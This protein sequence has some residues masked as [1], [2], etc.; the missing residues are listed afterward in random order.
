M[1]FIKKFEDIGVD[2][3][4]LVGGKNESLGRMIQDLADAGIAIP[5]GFAITSKAYW[6]YLEQNK[7][8]N[9]IEQLMRSI[10][11]IDD[12]PLVQ[13]VG[14]RVRTLLTNGTIP[15]DMASEIIEAYGELANKYKQDNCSVAVRSS[16]TA[17]DLPTASFAGQQ[18]T[19]LNVV[20][21]AELLDA[22]KKC[23]ASLFT[24]R[25]IVYRVEKG[26][27]HFDV[28][29]SIGV[30][31]MVR[32]DLASS[33]VAFSVDTETGFADAIIIN[34]S[35]GL[36]EAIVQGMVIPDEFVV[37]K[38]T[39]EKGFA[40]IIR[41][42]LGNKQSK[43]IYSQDQQKMVATVPTTEY[44]KNHFS[45]TNDQVLAL[46]KKVMIIE[47]YYSEK[48]G[49]WIP[50]DIEWAQDGHDGDLYIVQARPETIHSSKNNFACAQFSLT[51]D[52]GNPILTGHS[53]GQQIVAGRV[54][55]IAHA[56]DIDE[57]CD[58]DIVV[59][60]MTDPDW[61]P[62]MK[63]SSG[64]ITN[65]GGRTCHA[66]IVSRELGIPALVG[67][68]CATEKLHTGQEVTID[69]SRGS[70]GFVYA[71]ILASKKTEVI[72]ATL[73]K[74]PVKL[75]VNIA[76]PHAAFTIAQLPVEGVG[77]ARIEFII[78]NV[79]KIH[80][81]AVAH[82]DQIP[83]DLVRERIAKIT[84]AYDTV[85]QF[86]IDTL[87]QNI[88]MIAAAFYPKKVIVRLSDFKTNEYRNLIG[89]VFFEPVEENP[90]IGFRGAC[91]Y[92]HDRYKDAFALECAALKKARE[93]M[94]FTNIALMVPFV[95]TVDEAV[96]VLAELAMNGL[97]RGEKG[98]EII[99]MCEIPSN[100]ILIDEFCALFDGISIGSNDLTQLAL[101]IDRDSAIMA[102][103]FN[104]QDPAVKKLL[105]LA[106]AGARRNNVSSG[107][108]GQAPSDY[109]DLAEFL[110]KLGIDSVS[111]NPDSVIPF[112]MRYK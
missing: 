21:N 11:D 48:Q 93:I 51:V 40:P 16:A 74:S 75:L 23:I 102:D 22:C 89:G 68:Q 91:R 32:S 64:I 94:G 103:M 38:K 73:P 71:G 104:E 90:M 56:Q 4:G 69:C 65:R 76:D 100:V 83:D 78:S 79:I 110:I 2:D 36:G 60:D 101:G 26:F 80:P 58:G 35:Y 81:M 8:R 31:K 1:Q 108:C 9:E 25:A 61:V 107:I 33:G 98:L 77:L 39:L 15:D 20:G 99:M 14:M 63:R 37:H 96:R 3:I 106:V 12:I 72:S 30:Q 27:G 88:G 17:E 84:G 54:R 45:I 19:F 85:Q 87:A 44:E 67:T 34:S 43:I 111:L 42:E 57:F 49:R 24:H 55:V 62:I 97:K 10:T 52:P 59:T 29:L 70:Q 5:T 46:A 112:L 82:S 95:R 28:A 50:L 6:Y 66:A 47:R 105:A 13:S 53:I 109:P 18:E 92:Y 41:K 7:L 86:F